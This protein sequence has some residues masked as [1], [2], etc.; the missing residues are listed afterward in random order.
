MGSVVGDTVSGALVPDVKGPCSRPAGVGWPIAVAVARAGV[1]LVAEDTTTPKPTTRD[2][3]A[4]TVRIV[5]PRPPARGPV[6][7]PL[8]QS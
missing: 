3:A 7:A 6:I 2:P 5:V 8:P 1:D 4:A